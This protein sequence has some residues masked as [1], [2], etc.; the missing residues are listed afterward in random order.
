VFGAL[1]ALEGISVLAGT[2]GAG[3]LSRFV[4]IVPVLAVQGG[5][6]VVAGLVMLVHLRDGRRAGDELSERGRRALAAAR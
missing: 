3:Y 5:G 1:S 4:G 2:L 6:Y